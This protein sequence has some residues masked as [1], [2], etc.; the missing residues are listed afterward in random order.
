[1]KRGGFKRGSAL[2][3]VLGMMTVIVVSAVAFAA[4]MRYMRVPSSYLRQTSS[5]RLLAK[6]ALAEAIERIDCAIGN[7]PHP[8]II[9]NTYIYPRGRG[10]ELYNTWNDRVFI[11]GTNQTQTASTDHTVSVLNVEALA[12]LP[13]PIINEVRYWS[14]RSLAA[15]WEPMGFDAGH[16]AFCAVDVSD[17]IDINRVRCANLDWAEQPI[18]GRTSADNGRISLAYAFENANHTGYQTPDP[19]SWDSFMDSFIGGSGKVPLVSLA[20]FNLAANHQGWVSMSPFCN[21][22]KN[23]VLFVSSRTGDEAELLR[24]EVFV[25]D[26][27][28]SITNAANTVIDLS[29]DEDQP[30]YGYGTGKDDEKQNDVRLQELVMGPGNNFWNRFDQNSPLYN[31]PEVVMLYDYLDKDS[32][33]SSLAMP[34]MERTPMVCGVS[35]KDG[36]Q[37]TVG[38]EPGQ[39][40]EKADATDPNYKW[41]WRDY[42]LHLT[43]QIEVNVGTVYPFKYDHGR[44]LSYKVQAA[45]TIVFVP[46]EWDQ[47]RRENAIAQMVFSKNDWTT[48]QLQPTVKE[49]G[50][51]KLGKA[52][53]MQSN[54]V[55]VPIQKVTDGNAQ[56]EDVIGEDVSLSFGN[57]SGVQLTANLPE[58]QANGFDASTCSFRVSQRYQVSK[59]G[60]GM[61]GGTGG[62]SLGGLTPVGQPHV[63]YGWLPANK[64]LSDAEDLP[65]GEGKAQAGTYVPV[66]QLWVRIVDSNDETVDL[67]PAYVEDDKTPLTEKIEAEDAKISVKRPLVR[68]YDKDQKNG[69]VT[70]TAGDFDAISM[71]AGSEDIDVYPQAYLADDPR[72]NYAPENLVAMDTFSSASLGD[73]W[74]Q[75]QTS[76]SHD[77]DIFMATSDAGYMQSVYEFANILRISQINNS[78]DDGTMR[79]AFGQSP[80]KDAMWN[81]YSHGWNGTD[82]LD[83]FQIYSGTRG[84]R[85]NPYTPSTEVMMYALANTPIDWWAASTND[86]NDSAKAKMMESQS[87]ANKYAFSEMPGATIKM[88][89]GELNMNGKVEDENVGLLALAEKLKTTFRGSKDKWETAYENIAWQMNGEDISKIGGI[90]LD[91]NLHAVDRKYLYGYWKDCFATRQQLFLIFLRAEPMMMGGGI[92]GQTPPQLGARAVALV[93]RDPTATITDVSGSGSSGN[94][95]GNYMGE[96][97]ASGQPRP[98][99]TRVLFYRQFD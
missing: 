67:V 57:L 65:E 22:F 56:E 55:N 81:C 18:Y 76:A 14:R 48:S 29:S 26:S 91:V 10:V 88:K 21:F 40:H 38:V 54:M 71:D 17:Y 85:I 53:V 90:D 32:V 35:I 69:T 72:F 50:R 37:I 51:N 39:V 97:S 5:S 24:H 46:R 84:F 78:G 8:G 13:P 73:E 47:L 58:D 87:E 86:V 23:N 89:H 33:P 4:Y 52:I 7:N 92:L 3:I 44:N 2:L 36:S 79:K 68:F 12:Y 80:A 61:T 62:M 49:F 6:A 66:I 59:E 28:F 63:Q 43:G 15:I 75:N 41:K 25:T 9:N 19:D 98:H 95:T 31:Q 94:I 82:D 42:K 77:G 30:F 1:M 70:F 60:Q 93:W 45:A 99:R 83:G 16:Y 11:G 34:T 96:S 64:D 27:L 20:D 74:F